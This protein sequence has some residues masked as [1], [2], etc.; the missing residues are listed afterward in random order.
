MQ[1]RLLLAGTME[2]LFLSSAQG[3]LLAQQPTPSPEPPVDARTLA[4]A[5]FEADKP[6]RAVAIL[7]EAARKHPEDRVLGAMLYS[8][9]RDHVWHMPQILPVKHSGEVRALAFSDD[10][11][12]FAS[13]SASGEIWIS[14]T[15]P[16]DGKDPAA[17]RIV[18][19]NAESG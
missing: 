1:T 17:G 19:P 15:E 3:N 13:G 18:L 12:M 14:P 8:S 11:K 5:Y 2:F 7:A 16:K 6:R 10:G 4:D 9:L